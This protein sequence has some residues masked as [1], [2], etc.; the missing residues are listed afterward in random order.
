MA[1]EEA[2][3]WGVGGKARGEQLAARQRTEIK[4]SGSSRASFI[5]L[6]HARRLSLHL[7]CVG[8]TRKQG[9]LATAVL[10]HA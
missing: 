10:A 4:G 6:T 9:G 8:I 1:K 5:K 2:C 3:A 7:P